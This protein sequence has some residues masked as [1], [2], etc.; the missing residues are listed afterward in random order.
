MQAIIGLDK[1]KVDTSFDKSFLELQNGVNNSKK[2]AD[3]VLASVGADKL[4]KVEMPTESNTDDRS[5]T[6]GISVS[7]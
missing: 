6:G 2:A 4:K 7:V 1:M 3:S 5:G